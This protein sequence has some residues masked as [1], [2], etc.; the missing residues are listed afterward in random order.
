MPLELTQDEKALAQRFRLAA[1][2]VQYAKEDG[3]WITIGGHEEGGAKH[4]GGFPVLVGSDGTIKKGG[5]PG[6][7]GKKVSE[8]KSHFDQS[9][10]EKTKAKG[11]PAPEK[12]AEGG[13]VEGGKSEWM[14]KSDDRRIRRITETKISKDDVETREKLKADGWKYSGGSKTWYKIGFYPDAPGEH[15]YHVAAVPQNPNRVVGN[16]AWDLLREAQAKAKEYVDG[17]KLPETH[18]A[19]VPQKHD[20]R[21]AGTPMVD[22]VSVIRKQL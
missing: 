3:E 13:K 15:T 2:P 1:E 16:A 4:K 22:S 10:S 21:Y 14:P 17:L 12:A 5:P 11:N 8:V 9:R 6:I 18:K 19:A 7:V 20:G